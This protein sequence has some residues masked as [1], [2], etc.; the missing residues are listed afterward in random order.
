ME[1]QTLSLVVNVPVRFDLV[2]FL[3][4]LSMKKLCCEFISLIQAIGMSVVAIWRRQRIRERELRWPF[5]VQYSNTISDP[6]LPAATDG[7]DGKSEVQTQSVLNSI[8]FKP[9]K[10]N[11]VGN[12]PSTG[13]SS[14]LPY[15]PI[16][17]NRTIKGSHFHHDPSASWWYTPKNAVT[18]RDNHSSGHQQFTAPSHSTTRENFHPLLA[19]TIYLPLLVGEASIL[20]KLNCSSSRARSLTPL[21]IKDAP[22]IIKTNVPVVLDKLRSVTLKEC[23]SAYY[24]AG[25]TSGTTSWLLSVESPSHPI[26]KTKRKNFEF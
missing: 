17:I 24:R 11:L 4:S 12:R 5:S 3:V 26:Q 6:P 18:M 8:D 2:I 1:F 10:R 20:V 9:W 14:E 7:P 23:A 22:T 16:S 25:L 13:L 15:R 21:C 19:V